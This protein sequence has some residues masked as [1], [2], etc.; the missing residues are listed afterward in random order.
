MANY[1]TKQREVIL[2]FLN[3]NK[4]E[5]LTVSDILTKLKKEGIGQTTIYRFLNQLEKEKLIRKYQIENGLGCTYQLVDNECLDNHIHLKCMDCG[6][7]I[8]LDCKEMNYLIGHVNDNHKFNMDISKT[9]I[10]GKC[11]KC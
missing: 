8:H 7:L 10:Y 6:K 5:C 2:E 1:N 11:T 3:K 9:I 4:S